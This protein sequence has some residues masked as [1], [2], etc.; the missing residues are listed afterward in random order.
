MAHPGHKVV[1]IIGGFGYLGLRIASVLDN[2]GFKIFIASRKNKLAP[3][4]LKNTEIIKTNYKELEQFQKL[5][6]KIDFIIH[7]GGPSASEA[8]KNPA[9]SLYFNC[10]FT[11]RLIDLISKLQDK[12]HRRFIYLSSA[13]VYK[14]PLNGEFDEKSCPDNSHPYAVAHLC[15]E[16][17]VLNYSLKRSQYFSGLVLRLSNAVGAPIVNDCNCW[18]LIVNDIVKQYFTSKSIKIYS[19]P[20]T[21]RN[22]FPISSLERFLL[23]II[24]SKRNIK[25]FDL[26]NFGGDKQYTLAEISS[27]V[28]DRIENLFGEKV[29]IEFLSDD[30]NHPEKLNFSIQKLKSTHVLLQ[31]EINQEIDNLL[32]FCDTQMSS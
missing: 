6:P 15:A 31:E 27:I 1:L 26:F 14:S 3:P 22:F 5:L 13:H 29:N 17:A 18:G 9:E 11:W 30:K 7:A 25:S 21:Q 4:F 32:S 28:S 23:E 8:A 24:S 12:K 20:K 16:K 10:G 19:N 2:H